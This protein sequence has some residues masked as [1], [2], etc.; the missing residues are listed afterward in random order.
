MTL[1]LDC[2]VKYYPM[3]FTPAPYHLLAWGHRNINKLNQRQVANEALLKKLP[4][5]LFFLPGLLRKE[6]HCDG[7]EI[8]Q[9][10]S[11]LGLHFWQSSSWGRKVMFGKYCHYSLH[12]C[13]PARSSCIIFSPSQVQLRGDAKCDYWNLISSFVLRLTACCLDSVIFCCPFLL[14]L[15]NSSF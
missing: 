8:K 12:H 14:C 5:M 3:L 9:S 4:L 10:I 13:H 7:K 15:W 11:F 1:L 2:N 6:K